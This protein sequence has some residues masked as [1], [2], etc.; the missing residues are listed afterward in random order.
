MAV[1]TSNTEVKTS[2]WTLAASGAG[3]FQVEMTRRGE[4]ALAG[5]TPAAALT[6]HALAPGQRVAINLP[7]AIN[8]YVRAPGLEPVAMGGAYRVIVTSG[9]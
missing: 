7:S 8:L 3:E 4:Y 6:G 2:A 9:Q 5:S 1:A